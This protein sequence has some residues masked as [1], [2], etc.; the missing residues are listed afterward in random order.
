MNVVSWA[1]QQTEISGLENQN[2]LKEVC[3]WWLAGLLCSRLHSEVPKDV[4]ADWLADWWL[5]TV[6]QIN[7]ICPT[8]SICLPVEFS[9]VQ[10]TFVLFFVSSNFSICLLAWAAQDRSEYVEQSLDWQNISHNVSTFNLKIPKI[11]IFAIHTFPR[12][13]PCLVLSFKQKFKVNGEF[14]PRNW[15]AVRRFLLWCQFCPVGFF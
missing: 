13:Q 9:W 5:A 12:S 1:E 8:S 11:Q 3:S 10:S 15:N 2:I 4:T 7:T 6:P 14:F